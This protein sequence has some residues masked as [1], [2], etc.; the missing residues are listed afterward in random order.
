MIIRAKAP[1]RISFAGGGTD[2]PP[3]PQEHGGAVLCSTI[4][5]Y[6]YASILPADSGVAVHSLDYDLTVKYHSQ[7]DLVY[8]GKL[9]LVKAA[10]RIMEVGERG[11]EVYLHS[12]APPGSGLG[13]SSTVV[14]ALVGAIKHWLQ[15]PMTSYEVAETAY[16]IER[17]ELGIAGG[18][19][20]QYAAS[21][22]GFNFIEFLPDA[23]VVNPLR[24]R[25]DI[26]NE[27]QYN[28]LLCYTGGIRLSANI[29]EDQ[30]RNYR[31]GRANSV[32]GLKELKEIAYQMKNALL[33]GRLDD[34]GSLLHAGWENKKK[35]SSHITNPHINELYEVARREGALGGKLLGA[36]GGGYLL[37]YCP[38]TRKH[39]VAEA[40]ARAGGQVVEWNFEFSGL[41]SW[42]SNGGVIGASIRS[43]AV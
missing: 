24:I 37:L 11:A 10:L 35:L 18:M 27:L 32:E 38:Y 25:N 23:V 19:Q 17:L 13:S 40:L 4:N 43:T 42:E 6:A 8:D 16:R 9:D 28:L 15:R 5:K 12:D 30:V 29:I 21:F 34:F 22:G 14:V 33:L 31:E 41:Q 20:D 3:Y 1:L 39:T 26:V 36:G 7:E 2:V